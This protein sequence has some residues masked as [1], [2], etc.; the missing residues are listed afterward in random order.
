MDAGRPGRLIARAGSA[1]DHDPR[2][3]LGPQ[4][5]GELLLTGAREHHVAAVGENCKV[6][7]FVRWEVGEGIEVEKKDFAQE[8]AEQLKNN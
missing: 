7:R 2:R 6:R 1:A 5:V 3:A 8:I 4:P